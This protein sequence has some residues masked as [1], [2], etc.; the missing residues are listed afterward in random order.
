[1]FVW[2]FFLDRLRTIYLTRC[3][4]VLKSL[5]DKDLAQRTK[6]FGVPRQKVSMSG[7]ISHDKVSFQ[8]HQAYYNFGKQCALTAKERQ[9]KK[10]KNSGR[11]IHPDRVR[12][13]KSAAGLDI[14]V[15]D[16]VIIML[17]AILTVVLHHSV[18]VWA[19][20]QSSGAGNHQ[21]FHRSTICQ[22]KEDRNLLLLA[23]WNNGALSLHS[24]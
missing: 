3:C 4:S 12:I 10:K 13:R 11:G 9:K 8:F 14:L 1:M 19:S 20:A 23:C 7:Q 16:V 24:L 18:C 6:V 21:R 15:D 2:D 5:S 22:C 17:H